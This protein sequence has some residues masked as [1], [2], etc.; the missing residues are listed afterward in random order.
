MK[1]FK[2]NDHPFSAMS[3]VLWADA[4]FIRDISTLSELSDEQL[5]KS[6]VILHDL[7][8]SYDVVLFLLS[9]FDKRHG[10]TLAS[11]YNQALQK[12]GNVERL[13]INLKEYVDG[14]HP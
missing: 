5:L 14:S 6:A 7:Y 1:P 13:Y 2:I 3:Q 11:Y 9:Q 10:S 4:I 12:N 8:L